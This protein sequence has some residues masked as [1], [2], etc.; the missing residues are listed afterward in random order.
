MIMGTQREEE[1]FLT[2]NEGKR[3]MYDLTNINRLQGEN[4]SDSDNILRYTGHNKSI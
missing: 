3:S 2:E 4:P 1:A